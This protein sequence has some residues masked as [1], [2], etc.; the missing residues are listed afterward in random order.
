MKLSGEDSSI[1]IEVQGYQYPAATLKE[2]LNWL[3]CKVSF[4]HVNGAS[5]FNC[6]IR[7]FDLV[8]WM[9]SICTRMPEIVLS[10]PEDECSITLHNKDGHIRHVEFT[11]E[12]KLT[13]GF[14]SQKA[15]FT[16]QMALADVRSEVEELLLLYP[17]L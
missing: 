15:V 1:E 16:S 5:N 12:C 14:I 10:F 11:R 17:V 7:T 6:F 2:D 9:K 13:E 8:G 3:S 4:I